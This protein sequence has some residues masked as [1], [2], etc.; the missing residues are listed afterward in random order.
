MPGAVLYGCS[1]NAV[2]IC[3]ASAIVCQ[4]RQP[5]TQRRG[6]RSGIKPPAPTWRKQAFQKTPLDSVSCYPTLN[7]V[8]IWPNSA[9]GKTPFR[10]ASALRISFRRHDIRSGTGMFGE[11]KSV[12]SH[13]PGKRPG[14]FRRCSLSP[15]VFHVSMST[16]VS[17]PPGALTS[18]AKPEPARR[19]RVP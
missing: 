1:K 5:V 12:V 10:P 13:L 14:D 16:A 8:H 18:S 17:Y 9:T 2:F 4:V 6:A 3:H 11:P 15:K 19:S 7:Q